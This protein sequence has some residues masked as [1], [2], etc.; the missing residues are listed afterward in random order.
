VFVQVMSVPLQFWVSQ[1]V[2]C[3]SLHTKSP[4]AP[5]LA[6]VWLAGPQPVHADGR[7]S[8]LAPQASVPAVHWALG[9]VMH[10][11]V[12]EQLTSQQPPPPQAVSTVPHAQV[13]AQLPAPS[14]KSSQVSSVLYQ[15]LFAQ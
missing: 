11:T 2:C 4:P 1:G 7:V 6:T 14:Q 8:T 13:A 9:R 12:A 15:T 10:P 3:V 5:Q